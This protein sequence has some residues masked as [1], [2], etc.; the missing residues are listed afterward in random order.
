MEGEERGGGEGG[1]LSNA[2]TV[3]DVQVQSLPICE[4]LER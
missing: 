1:F 3:S 2:Q 4:A